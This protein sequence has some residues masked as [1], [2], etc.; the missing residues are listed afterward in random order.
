MSHFSLSNVTYLRTLSL[1]MPSPRY[2]SN[3]T[4][5]RTLG[6]ATSLFSLSNVTLYVPS[7]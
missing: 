2:N 7:V 5:L 3:V 6:I 4:F 1:A